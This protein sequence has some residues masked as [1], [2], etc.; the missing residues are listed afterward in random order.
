MHVVVHLKS[1][2][3]TTCTI[4]LHTLSF[5]IDMFRWFEAIEEEMKGLSVS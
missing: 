1:G 4:F 2:V 3:S 5:F